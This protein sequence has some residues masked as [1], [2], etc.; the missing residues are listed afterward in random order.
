[1]LMAVTLMLS[2]GYS[3]WLFNRIAHG[4]WPIQVASKAQDL[5]RRELLS[6]LP[7]VLLVFTLGLRPAALLRG[8]YSYAA[9]IS[10]VAM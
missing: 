2:G 7:I 1:M 9:Y 6:V 8:L 10:A 3:L 4:S 5:S